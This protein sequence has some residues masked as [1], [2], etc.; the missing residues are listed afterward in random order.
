MENDLVSV[1]VA[2]YNHENYIEESL[3]A[4]MN[5]T[6]QNLELILIDDGSKDSTYEKV[7]AMK[8]LLEKRF[9]NLH[10]EK[11]EN[12]GLVYTQQKLISHANGKY[13]F[14]IASDDVA[15]ENAIEIL[16]NF[17]S[18]NPEIDCVVGDNEFIDSN[19]TSVLMDEN[20]QIVSKK[21]FYGFKTFLEYANTRY[22][23]LYGK[24]L[25]CHN[26][27]ED[28]DY[29]PYYL[30]W[31]DHLIPIGLLIKTDVMKKCTNY[32]I[33]SPVDDVY[34]HYQLTKL[35]KEKVISD[36]LIKYRLHNTQTIN[37]VNHLN[38]AKMTRMYEMYLLDT[39]YPEFK[40]KKLEGSWWYEIHRKEWE[41]SKNSHLWDEEYYTKKYPEVLEQGWVPLVHYICVG[42]KNK[43]L[44]SK[45]FESIFHPVYKSNMLLKCNRKLFKSLKL[46]QRFK[47][48]YYGF[49]VILSQLFIVDLILNKK[50]RQH[51]H[52]SINKYWR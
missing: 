32:N 18:K 51:F 33:N 41:E 3:N 48:I 8:P 39:K 40:T 17:L 38:K 43:Y 35:G 45:Y 16:Y 12:K 4:L 9:T 22:L 49:M 34:M 11:Q 13:I 21:S 42:S 29:I 14:S 19:S 26:K 7:L 10:I 27:M 36:I 23:N 20:K 15:K 44:P 25:S 47:L 28:M 52:K 2:S 50:V 5:Q 31:Y 1:I 30:L 24:Q 6:Y 46:K 37:N